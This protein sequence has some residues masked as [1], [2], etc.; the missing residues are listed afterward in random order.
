MSTS[1]SAGRS[2]SRAVGNWPWSWS[3]RATSG[4]AANWGCPKRYW[5]ARARSTMSGPNSIAPFTGGT[6]VA[7]SNGHDGGAIVPEAVETLSTRLREPAWLHAQRQAAYT[8]YESLPMP[9]WS[10]GIGQWWKTDIRE[11][12]LENL[13][14]F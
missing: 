9:Q 13:H 11:V 10:R 6:A 5:P 1:W 8:T 2:S 14:L 7:T 12:K 4:C 3:K